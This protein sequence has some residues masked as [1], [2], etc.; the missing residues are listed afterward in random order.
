MRDDLS[1]PLHVPVG[2]EPTRSYWV[3]AHR[4]ALRA[5]RTRSHA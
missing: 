5:G 1:E 2:D 4:E 3:A